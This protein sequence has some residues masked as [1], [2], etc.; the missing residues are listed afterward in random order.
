MFRL[1]ISIDYSKE[2][3]IFSSITREGSNTWQEK[4]LKVIKQKEAKEKAQE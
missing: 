3:Y 2:I 1:H 4:E